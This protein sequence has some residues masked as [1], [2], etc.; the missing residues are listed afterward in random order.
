MG[1]AIFLSGYAFQDGQNLHVHTLSLNLHTVPNPKRVLKTELGT[2]LPGLLVRTSFRL[3]FLGSK[4]QV[5]NL[6]M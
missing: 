4:D 5:R 3:A 1:Y 2:S 6:K